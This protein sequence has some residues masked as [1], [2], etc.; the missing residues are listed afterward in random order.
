MV[1]SEFLSRKPQIAVY[2]AELKYPLVS[3][4]LAL[5]MLTL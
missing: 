5:P 1:F 2:R 4:A 3:A